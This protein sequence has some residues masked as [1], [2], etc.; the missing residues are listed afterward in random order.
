M[1]TLLS[2]CFCIRIYPTVRFRI[3]WNFYCF[4]CRLMCAKIEV[5]RPPSPTSPTFNITPSV[6]GREGPDPE[7]SVSSMPRK[8]E[9]QKGSDCRICHVIAMN[10]DYE[11]R[12]LQAL[13]AV[14]IACSVLSTTRPTMQQFF[15]QS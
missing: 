11:M 14:C 6:G 4:K 13:S 15:G 2:I 10:L 3:C 8:S 7:L 9:H 12:E 5:S 1:A